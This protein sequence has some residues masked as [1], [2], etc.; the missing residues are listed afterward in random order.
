[1]CPL[2]PGYSEMLRG[3]MVRPSSSPDPA[4][5]KRALREG[6]II[7]NMELED[8]TTAATIRDAIPTLVDFMWTSR[9]A[10]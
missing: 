7:K 5:Q 3:V 4:L 9:R 8:E 1:M 2:W 10:N 6:S